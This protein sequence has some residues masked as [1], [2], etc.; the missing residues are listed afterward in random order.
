MFQAKHFLV[1][2]LF[3]YHLFVA[4]QLSTHSLIYLSEEVSIINSSILEV[5]VHLMKCIVLKFNVYLVL[6]VSI[7]SSIRVFIQILLL[8]KPTAILFFYS[9]T[10]SW[11]GIAFVRVCRRGRKKYYSSYQY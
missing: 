5:Y 2:W 4:C 11:H 9:Y 7:Y 8:L 1:Y 10:A 6:S 3:I